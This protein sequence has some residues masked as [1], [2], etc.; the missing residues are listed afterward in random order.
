LGF[1]KA[2]SQFVLAL[3]TRLPFLVQ[4]AVCPLGLALG[5]GKA[6]SQFVLALLARLPFLVQDAV[7][8]L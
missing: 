2:P 8:L 5:F 7:C 3:L 4:E 1:G 6:P